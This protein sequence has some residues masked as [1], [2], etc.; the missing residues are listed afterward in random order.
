MEISDIYSPLLEQTLKAFEGKYLL[1]VPQNGL[2]SSLS[3]P[4]TR[5]PGI[6]K[7]IEGIVGQ[8][9][10]IIGEQDQLKNRLKLLQ[11]IKTNVDERHSQLQTR[12]NALF[13]K[14]IWYLNRNIHLICNRFDNN[15]PRFVKNLLN[16]IFPDYQ[17]AFDHNVS[18]YVACSSKLQETIQQIENKIPLN[19]NP[20]K[21][22]PRTVKCL[23]K[24]QEVL[25]TT[26][27]YYGQAIDNGD[28][29]F[30]AFAQSLNQVQ[31]KNLTVKD[32]RLAVKEYLE[33]LK[34]TKW[35]EEL[36]NVS[37]AKPKCSYEDFK[38]KVGYA[39]DQID[40]ALWGEERIEGVI[41]CR[42]YNVNLKVY[43]VG[44]YSEEASEIEKNENYWIGE[45]NVY[46]INEKYEQIVEI[47]LYPHHF[48][49]VFT[50]VKV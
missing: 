21:V 11:D 43:E 17:S 50:S 27:R 28:C 34:D 44:V 36:L 10:L 47:A 38:D 29:F 5:L 22:S 20:K 31:S 40:Y 35:I 23:D 16:F 45:D 48:I 4:I 30:D 13:F 24:L 37:S 39:G 1:L 14:V 42:L 19:P 41:L 32:L 46:P 12:V 18:S 15:I 49:P 33:N 9:G 7:E 25:S 3:K 6:Y 2:Y 26:S 8:N